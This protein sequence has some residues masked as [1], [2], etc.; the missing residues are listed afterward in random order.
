MHI[1]FRA[2][3]LSVLLLSIP[4]GLSAG[5][6]P[7]TLN[8]WPGTAPGE[9]GDIGAEKLQPANG[10]AHPI[11]RLENVSVPTIAFYPAS[12]EQNTGAAVVI[13]PGGGYYILAM[14]LEGTE[15]A[16][17]LNSIGVNAV[18]LK[19]RVPARK[20]LPRYLPPLQDAQRAMSLVR[21]RAGEWKLDP[22]RIGMLGFSAGGNLTAVASTNYQKRAY[23]MI[24][25]ID[26]V[27]CRPDF[28]VLIYPAW[29]VKEKTD[30]LA[31]EIPVTKQTPP[32]FI[33]QT[34]DD[35]INADSSVFMYVALKRA[36]V[37]AELHIFEKGGHG[38]GLRPSDNPVSHWPDLCAAW[39]KGR[40]F[41]EKR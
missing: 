23:E 25:E 21:S 22:H 12:A 2:A 8:V 5:E 32:M 14:D 33:L 15:I 10:E 40:G 20:G 18:V 36:G 26:K 27:D 38:Y 41:L 17:W 37:E 4:A 34:S 7:T 16:K 11:Q 39:M 30:E 6:A 24:D 13:C 28:G 9:K 31:S 1:T 35:P 19:Y 29:L 3:A